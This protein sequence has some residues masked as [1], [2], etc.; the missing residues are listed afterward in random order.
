M[1]QTNIIYAVVAVIVIALGGWYF[2]GNDATDPAT[3]TPA[4]TTSN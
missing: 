2:L 3:P 1:S 4:A